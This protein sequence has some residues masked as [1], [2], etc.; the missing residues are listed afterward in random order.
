MWPF[1]D[2]R[3]DVRYALRALRRSPGFAA[4]AILTLALGIGANTAIFSVVNAAVLRPIPYREPASL[5]LIETLPEDR[6]PSWL[7]T[8]WR[9][10]ARTL[11][12]FAGF[13]GPSAATLVASVEPGQV[14][15]ALI[16]WNFLSLLGVAPT[17][18]RDFVETDA[19]PG[20]PPVALLSHAL[21][22]TRF[23][24]DASVIGRT[25]RVSGDAVTVVGVTPSTFRFPAMATLTPASLA[26]DTQPGVLRVAGPRTPLNVIGR[27]APGTAAPA[28]RQ[29]LLAI[30]KQ[31][32]ASLLDDGQPEYS[33]SAVD[34][35]QL[36]AAP[37]QERLAG[38]VRERLWLA[39]GAVGFVLLVA[40][41]N[42]ANLLLARAS[43]RHRELAVRTAL[44]ARTGRLV[45][46]L[47]TESVLLALIGSA[48]GLLLAVSTSGL[49]RMVLAE[50]LPHIDTMAIDWWVLAFTV[51]VAAV[52]GLLCGLSSI[53]AA[54]RVSLTGVF[55][56]DTPAVTGRSTMRRILLSS[57]IAITFVLVVGAALLVQTLW[58]L[59][60]KDRGFEADRLL[61]VRVSPEAPRDRDGKAY[62]ALFF[63]DLRARLERVPGVVSAG[64]VSR[65]PL[66]GTVT[67]LS[68]IV[69]DGRGPRAA[70]STTPIAF[71]TP[72]YLGTMRIPLIAGRDFDERDRLGAERV[73]IVN[74]AFQRQ[75]APDGN[76]VG[77]RIT[78]VVEG[79]TVIGLTEDAPDRSLREGPEPLVMAP[80][81]QMPAGNITWTS[82]TFVL[83]TAGGDPLRLAPAVRKAIWAIDPD[84][85]ISE[86]ATM[87]ERVAQ[88]IRAER[89]SAVLFGLF[90]VAAL[91]MAA[92]GVYGVAAYAIVQ[93]TKEIGIRIALGA[94][95]RDVSRLVVSQTLVPTLIGVAVGIAGAAMVTKLVGSMVY[96]LTPLDPATFAAAILVLVSV[97]LGAT[98]LPARRAMRVDPLTALRSQ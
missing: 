43:A 79:F 19:A 56:G 76:I 38:N 49:A 85:V 46:L 31:V 11:S 65:A 92:I 47:L 44:G 75:F 2:V 70:E 90:A 80:L 71:V 84:I 33:P 28:A 30:Y 15:S 32:A 17:A 98:W 55:S 72:K 3:Q 58:N 42:V 50:R 37:L 26:L 94:A 95:R 23:G 40:C 5:V 67:G 13:N 22:M 35:L 10:R 66:T 48:L 86:V 1:D 36:E 7:T 24:G 21:W 91:V 64:A 45:R 8:A 59:S 93:R 83:R 6:A 41:A 9:E 27:L 25:V 60:T 62:F 68:N 63:T 18:G 57:E 88:T 54:T 69:V 74:R 29:E 34:R 14:Q 20:A 78:S 52:T 81:A 82:L 53:P 73:V 12:D 39:M 61:T 96:G 16:T 4:V 97:A 87:D 77:A 89:D 51:A